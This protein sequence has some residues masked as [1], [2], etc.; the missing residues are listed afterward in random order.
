[1][2][3]LPEPPGHLLSIAEYAALGED[4]RGWAS[5]RPWWAEV[6][7]HGAVSIARRL[8]RPARGTRQDQS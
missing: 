1:V 3:A 2:T 8:R 5:P 7:L 6:P 4:D